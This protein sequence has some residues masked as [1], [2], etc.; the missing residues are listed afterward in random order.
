MQVSA[1]ISVYPLQQLELSPAVEVVWQA[2]Q[3]HKLDYDPGAMSTLVHGD[4]ER[5]FAALK[6]ALESAAQLGPIVMVITLSNACPAL[7]LEES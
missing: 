5:L 7:P 2:M 4:T 6:D 1:Q 3:S